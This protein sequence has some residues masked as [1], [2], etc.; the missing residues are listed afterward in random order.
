MDTE[1]I[2]IIIT[3]VIVVVLFVFM[4]MFMKGK[5]KNEGGAG[6]GYLNEFGNENIAETG[7]ELVNR[8]PIRQ[9][10]DYLNLHKTIR[11]LRVSARNFE[12]ICDDIMDMVEDKESMDQRLQ[13]EEID[14][15]TYDQF[16]DNYT[17][18]VNKIN[19]IWEIRIT[20]Q[21]E[22]NV[23]YLDDIKIITEQLQ[24]AQQNGIFMGINK[25]SFEIP[26]VP[27]KEIVDALIKEIP[28]INQ[29][30]DFELI[31]EIKEYVSHHPI[32][33]FNIEFIHII[34]N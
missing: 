15:I 20:S 5:F 22:Y 6:F 16:M 17:S 13:N 28:Y 14:V 3:I 7:I 11:I 12:R 29:L 32:D 2:V 19:N 10:N 4:F 25:V 26:Q 24:T 1:T 18:I 9:L 31:D 33:G 34:Y 23:W 27:R 8:T 21:I 30:D